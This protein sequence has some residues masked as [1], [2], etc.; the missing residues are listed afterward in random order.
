MLCPTTTLDP[1]H[2]PASTDASDATLLAKHSLADQ[3][4]STTDT[5]HQVLKPYGVGIDTHSKFIQV[6]VLL[7]EDSKHSSTQVR[8]SEKEFPTTWPGILD[9]HKW[10]LAR[11][12][13]RATKADLRYCIEST[14]TYHFPILRAW[15]GVPTVVN[16]HLTAP[17]R[18]KTDVLDA[19]LLAHY[20]MTDLYPASFVPTDQTQL[21]RVLW[22]A[23]RE[24]VRVANRCSNRLNNIVLR[25]G[26]TFGRRCSMRSPEASGILED[27][28]SDRI[29]AVPDVSP[30]GLPPEVRPL[31]A[32][33]VADLQT[34]ITEVRKATAVAENFVKARDW[35]TGVGDLPGPNL[36]A[37]LRSVPGVGQNT[38]LA[39]LTE[40]GDPKRFL[41]SRQVA[42]FA[43]CDPSLK[44]SAGKVTSFV[45]RAGNLRLHQALLYSARAVM[46]SASEPLGRWGRSIAGRHKKGGYRKGTAAIARRIAV[47]LWHVHRKAEMFSY[48]QY[49][50]ASALQVPDVPLLSFLPP[51]AVRLLS[52][53]NIPSSSALALAYSEGKLSQIH[54]LGLKTLAVIKAWLT[55][56]GTPVRVRPIGS[57][58]TDAQQPKSKTYALKPALGF[59]KQSAHTKGQHGNTITPRP[60]R[61]TAQARTSSG[62]ARNARTRATTRSR[63]V[64]PSASCRA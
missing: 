35:P 48:A 22:G 60:S 28:L 15:R 24:A 14:G 47:A 63:R 26:H 55:E 49:T 21:L 31:I 36:L 42:A 51:R 38:A 53:N 46:A 4:R 44:V 56:H 11:L 59:P 5:L 16:P 12:N 41:N 25:F 58:D 61:S 13:S 18:R 30:E 10:T 37:I 6:C 32:A 39:W 45:R 7:L 17:T 62:S 50:L 29:P 54:G 20:S 52:D 3:V 2:T 8:R 19:R 57:A 1:P 27:L 34:H 33:L 43:G 23:R 40:I 9:A 64:A